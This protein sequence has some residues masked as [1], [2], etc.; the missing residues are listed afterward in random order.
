MDS[1]QI[2]LKEV[3]GG[4][5][6]LNDITNKTRISELKILF[7]KKK[8]TPIENIRMLF[9]GKD[10]DDNSTVEK[11]GIRKESTIIVVNRFP[12][13]AFIPPPKYFFGDTLNNFIIKTLMEDN[14]PNKSVIVIGGC[15]LG[16]ERVEKDYLI[17]ENTEYVM[18]H[19]LFKQQLPLP[20]IIDNYENNKDIHL[21]LIDPAFRNGVKG[22]FEPDIYDILQNT[23]EKVD[24]GHLKIYVGNVIDILKK[25]KINIFS[26]LEDKEILINI[27][28]IPYS[29]H[30]DEKNIL[31]EVLQT[32][33][34]EY[35]I[36]LK[37]IPHQTLENDN[38]ISNSNYQL[39]KKHKKWHNMEQFGGDLPKQYTAN[40]S[41]KDKNKQIKAIKKASKDYQK[42]KYTSRP[43]LKSFKSKKSNWTRK[44]EKKYGEDVKTYNEISKATG[45]PVGALK[46]VV[47]KGMGAY[48]SSGSRPNQTA[49]SWGKAR[50]YSYIMGGPT[51][52]VDHHITEK[53]NV[54]F[55]N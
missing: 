9:N 18:S 55:K 52:K 29:Y 36:Y 14:Y 50:M 46:A 41:K 53:Y 24:Y 12:S 45:I 2:F 5:S 7:H 22:E 16:S 35:F 39:V 26:Y 44:F 31:G 11:S 54:K 4:T 48:Y 28:V 34:T 40:L 47:K 27:Y 33:N 19:D 20:L 51:R 21:F 10:L 37:N 32:M 3:S 30:E 6:T 13:Q 42:G 17:E 25:I 23:C 49:E 15:K 38:F 8:G 43:K 1:F